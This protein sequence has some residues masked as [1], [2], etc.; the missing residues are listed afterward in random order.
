ME[1]I[2]EKHK[3]EIRTFLTGDRP[4][5]F[6]NCWRAMGVTDDRLINRYQSLCKKL[7]LTWH[8]L[9]DLDEELKSTFQLV[10][11]PLHDETIFHMGSF[12]Q[13]E[14]VYKQFKNI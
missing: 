4:A 12:A 7:K 13:L 8:H 9:D 5:D 1:K 6:K 14:E 3:G 10:S 11:T 2:V